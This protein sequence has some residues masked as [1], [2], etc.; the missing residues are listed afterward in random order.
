MQLQSPFHTMAQ[1]AVQWGRLGRLRKGMGVASRTLARG[2]LNSLS[3]DPEHRAKFPWHIRLKIKIGL[4][5]SCHQRYGPVVMEQGTSDERPC[6]SRGWKP[7]NPSAA[8]SLCPRNPGVTKTG[9]FHIMGKTQ[10]EIYSSLKGTPEKSA[11][12][13][14][15]SM[16]GRRDG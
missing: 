11:P 2:V 14:Q 10:T 6:S 3:T 1:G 13:P 12:H 9:G 4:S 5:Y 15:P 16:G 8:H 7:G